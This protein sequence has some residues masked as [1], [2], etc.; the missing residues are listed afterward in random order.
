MV[1]FVKDFS[2]SIVMII[3]FSSLVYGYELAHAIM[4]VEKSPDLQSEG[5]RTRIADG[6]SSGPSVKGGED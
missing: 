2:V 4:E 3:W 6:V 1:N 5:L